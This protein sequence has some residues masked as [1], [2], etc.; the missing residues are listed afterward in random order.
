MLIASLVSAGVIMPSAASASPTVS[1]RTADAVFGKYR[2]TVR[3]RWAAHINVHGGRTRRQVFEIGKRC[4]GSRCQIA[5]LLD[6]H[7]LGIIG[8]TQGRYHVVL[9]DRTH[10]AVSG[11][12]TVNAFHVSFTVHGASIEGTESLVNTACGVRSSELVTFR[13]HRIGR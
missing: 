8:R 9:R 5:W 10:C 7:A 11:K 13:G 6:G 1:R 3:L 4:S 12:P 2:I